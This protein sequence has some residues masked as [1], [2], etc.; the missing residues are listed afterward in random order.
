MKLYADAG[1]APV[2]LRHGRLAVAGIF[3]NASWRFTHGAD[4]RFADCDVGLLCSA[5]PLSG[6]TGGATLRA[7]MSTWVAGV[8]WET[9]DRKLS[10]EFAAIV[11]RVVGPG[12]MRIEGAESLR[13]LR[14]DKPLRVMRRL[15]PQY[16]PKEQHTAL[17]YQPHRFEVLSA[18][19]FLSVSGGRW[20]NGSLPDVRR[21]QLPTLTAEQADRIVSQVEA[22]FNTRGARPWIR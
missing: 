18:A 22:L 5:R 1:Y 15:P 11:E 21:E 20:V 8:R 13:V 3:A 17:D 2:P 4:A 19:T 10:A 7:V 12:P 14:V 16:L 9:S 6:A